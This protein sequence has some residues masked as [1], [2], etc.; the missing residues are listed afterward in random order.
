MSTSERS[1]SRGRASGFQLTGRGGAGNFRSPSREPVPGE[2]GPDDY[3][4]TRGR[5]PI[6]SLDPNVVTSTGRGG[7]G[8]IRSPSRDAVR[9]EDKSFEGSPTRSE[10]RGRGY[11]RD[12]ISTIDNANDTGV[13][14]FGRGGKGNMS[15]SPPNSQS[16]SRSREPIHAAGRGGFGNIHAGGP[17]E[18]VIEE[19]DESERAAHLHPPGLHSTG[20]GGAANLS[21]GKVPYPEGAGNPHGANHPHKSHEHETESFGRGGRG[22][23]SRDHS[24]EPGPRNTHNAPSGLA[25][26][27]SASG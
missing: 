12:L 24:R 25:Q 1:L 5:D 11:D 18:K 4:D 26:S 27:V 23:I 17:S 9:G 7:A 22:N 20:R 16:R 14:S 10:Q 3:S 6:P 13:H 15:P 2:R 8:N 21:S 19:Q